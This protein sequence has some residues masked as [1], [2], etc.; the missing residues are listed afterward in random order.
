MEDGRWKMEV[1]GIKLSV[2][3]LISTFIFRQEVG[4]WKSEVFVVSLQS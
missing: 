3:T 1:F 4:R 2:S